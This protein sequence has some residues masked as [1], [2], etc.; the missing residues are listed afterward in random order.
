MFGF[1]DQVLGFLD[2]VFHVVQFIDIPH[3]VILDELVFVAAQGKDGGRV[4][5][6]VFPVVF[7]E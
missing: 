1:E 5:E 3:A 7:I 4:W 2:V 6:V